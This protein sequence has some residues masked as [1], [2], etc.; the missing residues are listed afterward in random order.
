MSYRG[1]D[2]ISAMN[3]HEAMGIAGGRLSSMTSLIYWCCIIHGISD[4]CLCVLF[5][6][7]GLS[8][9]CLGKGGPSLPEEHQETVPVH[10]I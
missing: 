3:Y 4:V 1:H 5:A 7:F 10:S 2:S 6:G 9:A 8:G